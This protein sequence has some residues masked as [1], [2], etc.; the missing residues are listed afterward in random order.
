MELVDAGK[1]GKFDKVYLKALKHWLDILK[2][3]MP[4]VK[5]IVEDK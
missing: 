4:E 1:Y 2:L 5:A 3:P